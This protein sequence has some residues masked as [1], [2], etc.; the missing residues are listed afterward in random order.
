M[1]QRLDEAGWTVPLRLFA[2]WM[3]MWALGVLLGE[4]TE[5]GDLGGEEP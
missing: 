2:A 5:P 3:G 4:D 1:G